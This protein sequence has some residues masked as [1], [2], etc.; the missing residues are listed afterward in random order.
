MTER[1]LSSPAALLARPIV[2]G[3]LSVRQAL[4]EKVESLLATGAGRAL[5]IASP[6]ALDVA[7]SW[8]IMGTWLRAE[9][10]TFRAGT[11]R[12]WCHGL[13]APGGMSK[14]CKPGCNGI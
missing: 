4:R 14:T 6:P 1:Y 9:P 8:S 13:L 12:T 2:D 10:D 3:V 7:A 5:F 11:V